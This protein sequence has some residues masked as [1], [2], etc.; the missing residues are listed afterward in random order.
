VDLR[1]KSRGWEAL[2]RLK[3]TLGAMATEV[4]IKLERRARIDTA[5]IEYKILLIILKSRL[6]KC[7]VFCSLNTILT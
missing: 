4:D 3:T 1:H 2:L 6:A 7:Q 5:A